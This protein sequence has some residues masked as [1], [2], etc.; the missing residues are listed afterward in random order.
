M[1]KRFSLIF[2]ILAHFPFSSAAIAK[3]PPETSPQ[4][5]SSHEATRTKQILSTE[6]TQII[7]AKAK[8]RVPP[9]FPISEAK[10]GIDG[11]VRLS[12]IVEPDGST[13]NVVILESTGRK[14]FEREALKA[15]KQWQ[16]EPAMEGGKPIQQCKN[17]VQIDF[18]M[19]REQEGVSRRFLSLYR[20]LEKAFNKN[21][22]KDITELIDRLESYE[23]KTLRESFYKYQLMTRYAK[24][25]QNKRK[26]LNY[27]NKTFQFSG[28]GGFF[29]HKRAVQS[30]TV[31]AVGVKVK[32][33]ESVD[34]AISA[35]TQRHYKFLDVALFPVLHDK[36]LLELDFGRVGDALDT[37]DKLLLLS[38]AKPNWPA[39]QQQKQTLIDFIASDTPIVTPGFIGK[40]DFWQHT[41]IRNEFQLADVSGELH[42]LDIRCRNKRHVYTVNEQ[43]IWKIP[44]SWQG[45][46]V[47]VYGDNKASFKL[48]ELNPSDT[49]KQLKGAMAEKPRLQG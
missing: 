21:I 3:L 25:Q 14:S 36:L 19:A 12:F 40:R 4:E 5:Q 33:G 44:K 49:A 10:K 43:S 18:K 11:W 2:L 26:E 6:I 34:E 41:L 16:Y 46:N 30:D 35:S 27:L 8:L 42:K 45:C 22:Q 13:S 7:D 29:D 20:K 17:S 1:N 48:V 37:V 28:V 32:K 15:L 47:L 39:Y 38:S 23:V 24:H 9:K 31:D